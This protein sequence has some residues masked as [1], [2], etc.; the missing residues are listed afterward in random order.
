MD[1]T[2]GNDDIDKFIQDIQLSTHDN[3]KEVLEWI[4]YDR[5]YDIKD[6]TKDKFGEV[7]RANWIDG[8]IIYWNDENQNWE[9]NGHNMIVKLKSLNALENLTLEFTNKV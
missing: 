3:A 7:Y 1:W 2:S 5:L 9:R 6:I 4:P 8:Y